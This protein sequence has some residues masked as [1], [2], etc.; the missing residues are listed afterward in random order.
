MLCA[1][2]YN[3]KTGKIWNYA[4]FSMAQRLGTPG[5][6][7]KNRQKEVL[8]QTEVY[9]NFLLVSMEVQIRIIQQMLRG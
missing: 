6:W 2:C 5:I 7:H 9:N 3:K 4:F 1:R 8:K